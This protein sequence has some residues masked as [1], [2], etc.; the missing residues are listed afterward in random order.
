MQSGNLRP[1]KGRA[2]LSPLVGWCK[3]VGR[4]EWDEQVRDPAVAVTP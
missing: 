1:N 3:W 2:F 4:T